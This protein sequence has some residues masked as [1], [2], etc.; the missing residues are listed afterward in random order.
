MRGRGCAGGD[1]R[2]RRQ[3]A[4]RGGGAACPLQVTADI[5][6]YLA[7][8]SAG[9]CGPCVFGLPRLSAQVHALARG[10]RGAAAGI[11]RQA[12]LVA[13]RGACHHPDG[14]AR[15]ARSAARVFAVEAAAHAVGACQMRGAA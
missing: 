15:V 8:Q 12:E 7:A 2:V 14:A 10:E 6:A 11:E 13:G 9:Q 4:G 1:D 5:V 3:A